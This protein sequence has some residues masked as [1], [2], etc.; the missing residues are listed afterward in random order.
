MVSKR[1]QSNSDPAA[2]VVT[3]RACISWA[4]GDLRRSALSPLLS[5]L[6]V[7]ETEDSE[8]R[9]SIG[10]VDPVRGIIYLN[11]WFVGPKNRLLDADEWKYAIAHL[12]LHLALNHPAR[13]EGRDPL[14]WN[15]ACDVA[16]D[17]LLVLFKI[18]RPM[19]IAGEQW[20]GEGSE[21][22]LYEEMLE[23]R[24]VNRKLL[25]NRTLA[26]DGRTDILG[27]AKPSLPWRKEDEARLAT[28]IR[29]VVQ[30]TVTRTAET[31]L[32]AETGTGREKLWA[33]AERAKHWVLSEFPLLGALA[34]EIRII[35]DAELCRRM[36]IPIAAINGF[37]GEMYLHPEVGLTQDE[38][39]FVYVHELL[40]VALFHHSRGM[41]RDP[42]L[43]NIAAD[44]VI[45][46][47][48]VE[49]GVGQMPSIAA[50]YD[51]RL[52]GMST[53]EV[54]DY[55][56]QNPRAAKKMRGFR[57][58]LGDV[59]MDAPNGRT[60]YRKDV[61]TLDDLYRR[62][63][64][65]GYS[66]IGRGTIPAGLL[67]EIRSLWTAPVPWDVELAQWMDAHVPF[68]RDP[69]RTYA[70]ASR[71][72]A[73]TPD[74]PRPARYIPQEEIAACTFGVVLDTSGSMDRALLGRALGAIAS[75]AEA[76][77]VNSV[78]LVLCD[79]APY[80]RGIVSPTDLRGIV[81]V[82]GRGGTVLQPAIN[83]LIRRA[84]F[85]PTAPIMIITDGW[86]EEEILCPRDHCFVLPRATQVDA[87]VKGERI[88]LRTNAPVFRVLKEN[89]EL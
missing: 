27:L 67:E 52:Q 29:Q 36:D 5:A 13:R 38:L 31:L 74:I 11:P 14:I 51:P 55:I 28:C 2:R 47:W 59:L 21:D 83:F 87:K 84:D 60:I 33:P 44:F 82:Q 17:R 54:Y 12:A 64:R 18:Y 25:P 69:R 58:A 9:P 6:T 85:P 88:P 66:C 80:D 73:S 10:A 34:G 23:I 32:F 79:A 77:D 46:G 43:Y 63:L 24:N 48:L 57:G 30:D 56:A 35:A 39:I 45:N 8:T 62:C 41:G 26:G 65:T 1:K 49:M 70:R 20:P 50:L 71:R 40:H 75:Y 76:R 15:L 19:T 22:A 86:C 42:H 3:T 4:T 16:V 37:L 81:S 7:T 61:T 78:R 53:E 89:H 68:P 72:Q